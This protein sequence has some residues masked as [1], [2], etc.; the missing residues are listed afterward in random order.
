MAFLQLRTKVKWDWCKHPSC[1]LTRIGLS[2]L[3]QLKKHL[4]ITVNTLR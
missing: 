2:K 3:E 1:F 4:T